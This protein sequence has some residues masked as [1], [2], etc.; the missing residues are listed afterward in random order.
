VGIATIGLVAVTYGQFCPKVA[1]LR[2]AHAN[3][4]DA[5]GSEIAARWTAGALVALIALVARDA[6][7]FVMGG[8]AVVAYSWQHRY[9]NTYDTIS[10]HAIM[11]SSR[12][13]LHQGDGVPAG[14][15]PSS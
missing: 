3:D 7:V 8:A 4:R 13:Q 11:P 9:A 10:G 15:T 12:V 5:T 14:Y 1:D 6:T 2:V